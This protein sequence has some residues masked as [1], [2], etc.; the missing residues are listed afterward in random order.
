M[1]IWFFLLLAIVVSTTPRALADNYSSSNFIVKDPVF[2][3]GSGYSSSSNFQLWN[4][5][6]QSAI[7]TS[8]APSF[9][10]KSGFLYF[11]NPSPSPTPS[12]SP[13]PTP[14][15]SPIGGGGIVGLINTII[16]VLLTPPGVPPVVQSK[17]P[18]TR[19]GCRRSDFNCDGR[20]DLQD[21]SIFFAFQS[22]VKLRDLSVVFS[23]WTQVLPAFAEAPLVAIPGVEK[24]PGSGI[25]NVPLSG[26][27]LAEAQKTILEGGSSANHATSSPSLGSKIKGFFSQVVSFIGNTLRSFG[28]ILVR[29]FGF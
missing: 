7:G 18:V 6:G 26:T 21:L 27:G 4:S 9:G 2:S 15:P 20:V 16:Q 12:P 17:P 14:S 1:K 11:T 13:S 25:K 5:V 22:T 24:I 29:L 8:T 23:D 19:P 28:R 3:S 10:L